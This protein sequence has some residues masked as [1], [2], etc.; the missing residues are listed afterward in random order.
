MQIKSEVN[1]RVSGDLSR[2][3]TG[4]AWDIFYE[5]SDMSMQLFGIH[6]AI[7]R[8]IQADLGES[9]D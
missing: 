4:P 9:H 1:H 2:Y 5:Y 3:V 6:G 8:Q 7:R